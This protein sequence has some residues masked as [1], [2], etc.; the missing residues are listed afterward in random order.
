MSE[1]PKTDSIQK[2]CPRCGN[3][4]LCYEKNIEF[5]KC[6]TIQLSKKLYE[7]IHKKYSDCLCAECLKFMAEH[8]KW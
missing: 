1:L 6:K 3:I 8:Q 5:C 4:F 2:T 7:E